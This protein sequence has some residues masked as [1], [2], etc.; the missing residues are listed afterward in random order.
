MYMLMLGLIIGGLLLGLLWAVLWLFYDFRKYKKRHHFIL[1]A[2]F[3]V[4]SL[5]AQQIINQSDSTIVKRPLLLLS[6]ASASPTIFGRN[7]FT[8]QH[9]SFEPNVNLATPGNYVLGPGDEVIID[10]WGVSENSIRQMISPEG[11][12]M[13]ANLGPIYLSGK[14]VKEANAYLRHAFSKIYSSI[15]G[16]QASVKL[17]LGQIRSIQMNVMGEVTVPGTYTL[18]SFASVFHA[19]YC[20]GGVSPIG[21]LR[22]IQLVRNG[23]KVADVDVYDYILQGKM[24]D[25][26]RL[27]EGDVILVP[28]Y[29]CLINISGKVKRPMFYE[30]KRGE[31]LLTLLN[32]A[33]GF[34]GDSYQSNIRLE[35]KSDSERQIYNVDRADYNTFGLMDGD[36]LTVGAVLDRFANKIEVRGAVYRQGLYQ[37]SAMTNTV[38]QLIRQAEGLR[39]DAFLNRSLLRREREDLSLE[40]IPINLKGIVDGSVADIPLQRNDVLYIS[41][42]QELKEEATLN[43]SGEVARPGSFPF[44]DNMTI[45]DL[46]IKAGGLLESASFVGI[47]VARRIKKPKSKEAALTLGKTFTLE[48]K[49]GSLSGED[50]EFILEPFD[51]VMVRKSPAYR[52]Q[53]NV[54]MAGE[55]LFPGNY[56]LMKKNERLSD[57]VSKAGGLTKDAYVRGAR[58]IRR[59]T[60]E[61][62]KQQKDVIRLAENKQ[63]RDSISLAG[64]DKLY[65]VGI[66]LDKALKHP[67]SADDMVLREGDLLFIPEFVSTVKVNGEVMYP[68]TVLYEDGADLKHYVNEAGGYG[69]N[70]QKRRAYVIRLNGT[71][72]RLRGNSSKGIEPGCEIIVP[73]KEKR[74][75]TSVADAMGMSSSIATLSMMIATMTNLTK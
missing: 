20:A 62:G 49:D 1:L 42:V 36:E 55:V 58:M 10:V 45:K 47:D 46:I 29:D 71:V 30:M 68:N 35:R 13:V 39:G 34:T 11:T 57:L 8:T 32:F 52:R 21:S 19:L 70:A 22:N 40:M 27:M 6:D 61:E 75:K 48:L 43:I 7:I 60:D 59:M 28:P 33:G 24:K 2:L 26:I 4:G 3:S 17:T 67:G 41:S 74:N 25:D 44:A 63:G 31:T 56:A 14:S 54:M 72:C 66:E 73:S 50:V 15:A 16:Q 18:S 23:K 69:F 64:I 9:L 65:S 37:L 12:I 5:S 51:R 38:K 53:K